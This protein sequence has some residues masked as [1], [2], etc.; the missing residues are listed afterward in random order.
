[1]CSVH[2]YTHRLMCLLCNSECSFWRLLF[3][4][5]NFPPS[6]YFAILGSILHPWH[7]SAPRKAAK[8]GGQWWPLPVIGTNFLIRSLPPPSPCLAR[9]TPKFFSFYL[10]QFELKP[11][12]MCTWSTK[13]HL[14]KL[15]NIDHLL[16]NID[17]LIACD[18]SQVFYE[19]HVSHWKWVLCLHLPSHSVTNLWNLSLFHGINL[20]RSIRHK[21]AFWVTISAGEGSPFTQNWVPILTKLGPH[22][23]REQ[24]NSPSRL[25]CSITSISDNERCNK[26]TTSK[27][28]LPWSPSWSIWKEGIHVS[29]AINSSLFCWMKGQWQERHPLYWF[30]LLHPLH[31]GHP[32]YM[33]IRQRQHCYCTSFQIMWLL[34]KSLARDFF[35]NFRFEHF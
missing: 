32:G 13:N 1:M 26:P 3:E 27:S 8:E 2:I 18:K 9:V 12:I 21:N 35:S 16:S 24:W 33:C 17:H 4:M 10:W 19:F 25:N 34:K 28:I 11:Y 30:Y 20:F 14:K 23:M 7:C 15:S 6:N 29:E 5:H 31:A 22:R